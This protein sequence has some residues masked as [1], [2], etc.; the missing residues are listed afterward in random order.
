[1]KGN[2]NKKWL[3]VFC[4]AF[5]GISSIVVAYNTTVGKTEKDAFEN[6]VAPKQTEN[7]ENA[8]YIADLT[9]QLTNLTSQ[10]AKLDQQVSELN[11][12]LTQ[13]ETENSNLKQRLKAYQDSLNDIQS[14]LKSLEQ[15]DLIRELVENLR[16]EQPESTLAP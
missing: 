5:L 1:M 16:N 13:K 10:I 12:T 8:S 14:Q 7:N 4:V 9:S 2:L 11:C 3:F 6:H 15:I